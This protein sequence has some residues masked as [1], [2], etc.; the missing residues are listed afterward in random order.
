MLWLPGLGRM[1]CWQCPSCPSWHRV[2]NDAVAV[3]PLAG[4]HNT[5]LHDPTAPTGDFERCR[6][7]QGE[8]V[9]VY[10]ACCGLPDS[11]LR[12]CVWC[13][14]APHALVG[15]GVLVAG[16]SRVVYRSML[17]AFID[18]VVWPQWCSCRSAGPH[19]VSRFCGRRLTPLF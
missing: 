18:E 17:A 3:Q 13:V 12:P 19:A 2:A 11:P 14:A 16:P 8:L 1:A 5:S 4:L 6:T 10:D 15:P 7:F 9:S